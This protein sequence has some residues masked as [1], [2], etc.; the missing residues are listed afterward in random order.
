MIRK[1]NLFLTLGVTGAI[2]AFFI[3]CFDTLLKQG[4]I[5]GA[6]AAFKAK[7][8]I[9]KVDTS[10]LHGKISIIGLK[11]ANKNEPMT[12]L[13]EW[14]KATFQLL[15]KP[16]L[17]MKVV[18]NLASIDGL[19]FNTARK[20]SGELPKK[21]AKKLATDEKPSV[22]Q[23]KLSESMGEAKDFSADRLG[24]VKETGTSKI[25]AVKP[26]NLESLKVLDEGQSKIDAL[27]TKWSEKNKTIETDTKAKTDRLQADI[28]AVKASGGSDPKAIA[29]RLKRLKDI[30][31]GIKE[32]SQE[33]KT[34]KDQANADFKEAKGLIDKAKEA[35]KRDLAAVSDLI[36]LPKLDAESIS[37]AL[38]G[39]QVKAK[40]GQV[41]GLIETA[42]EYLPDRS[43]AVEAKKS[44]LK[45]GVDIRFPKDAAYPTFL[46]KE[47]SV[48]GTWPM[49]TGPLTFA[50]ALKD[51]TNSPSVWL[52]PLTG[53]L[54][55]AES[56]RKLDALMTLDHRKEPGHDELKLRI[57]GAPVTGMRLGGSGGFALTL[58]G[59]SASTDLLVA[60]TGEGWKGL[61]K[62]AVTGAQLEPQGGASGALGGR[63]DTIVRSIKEFSV[64]VGFEGKPDDL[65]FKLSSDL[66]KRISE[67][68]KAALS[69]EV[70]D[71]KR[72]LQAK[73]DSLYDAKAQALEAKLSGLQS[74]VLGKLGSHDKRLDDLLNKSKEEDSPI[75]KLIPADLKGFKKL[76]K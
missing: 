4:M 38:L 14:D 9:A 13:F 34:N 59:G 12:N 48:S 22:V 29:E 51:A 41:L 21:I 53:T 19:T 30:Q 17:E 55:G 36:G 44:N 40:L 60:R 52:K 8:E 15:T 32:L 54:K 31:K 76:F 73:I 75:K 63:L 25:D 39:A 24:S 65:D 45:R 10:I 49:A 43:K 28:D 18:I 56:G 68:L 23:Q 20:S 58:T 26:E 16:L 71:Q 5:M 70:D 3:I 7:V 47:A 2:A 61:V 69:K 35:K 72:A 62:V 37:K 33:L 46:L 6:E 1:G 64:T 57:E 66:G 27:N 11:V 50:G 42:K 74:G 67:G